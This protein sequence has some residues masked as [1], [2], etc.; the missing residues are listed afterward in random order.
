MEQHISETIQQYRDL[1]PKLKRLKDNIKNAL[2]Q[3]INEEHIPVFSIEARLKDEES[4]EDKIGRKQYSSP[5]NQIEDL[6]G[7]RVICYYQEDIEKICSIV[8]REFHILKK[9]DK[10]TSLNEDQFGYTSCHYIVKLEEEWLKHP[11]ARGLKGLKAE[12]QIRTMLMHAW[13][14]ISHKLLYK[15]DDDVPSQFKRQLNRLSAL[16]ELADEQFDSIK[17]VKTKLTT[18][19]ATSKKPNNISSELTSDS[20]VAIHQKYFKNRIFEDGDAA[21]ILEEIRSIGYKFSD[22]IEHIESC[23]PFLDQLEAEEAELTD[24]SLPLWSFGGAIRTILDLTSETYRKRR[25]LPND[26]MEIS[27]KYIKKLSSA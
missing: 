4:I 16:I 19:L 21:R 22:L 9:E 1:K 13:S 26:L 6:C 8:E 20:L 7:L 5:I 17:N 2:H 10:K 23:L 27:R 12:I 3:T 25:H 24:S 11:S 18:D 14:A 15:K